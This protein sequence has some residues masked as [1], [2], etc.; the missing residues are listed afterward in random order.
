M[1]VVA[2]VAVRHTVISKYTCSTSLLLY[3][4]VVVVVLQ[5]PKLIK[6]IYHNYGANLN[7]SQSF[8]FRSVQSQGQQPAGRNLKPSCMWFIFGIYYFP[9]CPCRL[10]LWAYKKDKL[11][12]LRNVPSDIFL[13]TTTTTTILYIVVSWRLAEEGQ[14]EVLLRHKTIH[15]VEDNKLCNA[16][17]LLI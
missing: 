14:K 13:P 5:S 1:S 10:R 6:S 9:F 3:C 4:D 7:I 17:W 12:V 15:R 16:V 2:V 8:R 11:N